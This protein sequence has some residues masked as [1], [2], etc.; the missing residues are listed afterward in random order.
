MSVRNRLWFGG[1]D[2][3]GVRYKVGING[4][5][6]WL[7]IVYR[8]RVD[9]NRGKVVTTYLIKCLPEAVLQRLV[10]ANV[11]LN[12]GKGVFNV[13]SV[14]FLGKSSELMASKLISTRSKQSLICHTPPTFTK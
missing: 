10:N 14:K 11:T 7:S 2:R 12:A 1:W 6:K 3:S 4:L 13:S 9:R 8:N 5:E